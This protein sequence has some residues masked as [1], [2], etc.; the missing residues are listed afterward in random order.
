MIDSLGPG[1][2]EQTLKAVVSK[3]DRDRFDVRVAVLQD[4][5]G[6]PL[7]DQIRRLG[8]SVDLIG[9]PRLRSPG[10]NVRVLRYL[11]DRRPRVIHTHLE[12]SHTLGGIYGRV[13]GAASVATMHAFAS[14]GTGLTD[15]RLNLM[16]WSLRHAHAE[17]IAPSRAAL[18]YIQAKGGVPEAKVR[19]MHN[20]VDLERFRPDVGRRAG[21]RAELGIALEAK[22]LVTV[23]VLRQ[24]K[25]IDD[26]IAAMPQIAKETFDVVAI[27]VG[28]GELR[29]ELETQADQTGVRDRFVFTGRREDVPDLLRASDL[30][31]LPTYEDVLPTVVAEAMGV[32]LPVVSTD[33][34]GLRDMVVEEETGLFYTPGDVDALARHANDLLHDS[35]KRAQFGAAGRLRAK[36]RFDLTSQV[37]ELERLYETYATR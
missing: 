6:N 14:G 8:T 31:V 20:G 17:V 21:T 1:G 29:A 25:G 16:W 12:F 34:G 10:G 15:K 2:A 35:E 11:Y 28:D 24:G 9:V 3:M 36:E 7:A 13:V 4:R 18:E 5:L 30:F 37:R 22:V 33:V 27:V 26:L 23:A 32:G 19:L